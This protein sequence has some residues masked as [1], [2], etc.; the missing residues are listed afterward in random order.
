MGKTYAMLQEA[1]G[2]A[3]AG[4]DVVVGLVETHGRAE[5]E[6]LLTGLEILPRQHLDYRG[7][8]LDDLD[9]DAL[10]ARRPQL[11]LVDEL[12]HTNVPGARH[13][14][15]WQDVAEA[16]DAGI[17][18][19]TTLNIQ[20]IESLNDAVARITGVRVQETV[21]D[22]IVARADEIEL[23]DLPPEELIGRLRDGKVYREGTVGRALDNFFTKPNLTAL[24]EL[25]L[26][27]A[28]SRVDQQM[29]SL[30]QQGAV[31][32][33]WPTQDRILV[34]I[35]ESPLAK[36]LVR[37]GKRM[38]ER[39]DVPWIAI[40]VITPRH[41]GL[42][43]TARRMTTEALQLA[44]A[45]GAETVTLRA[46]PGTADAIIGFARARNATRSFSDP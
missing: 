4:V 3:K 26:R 7:Q 31:K 34:C 18:V 37:A 21:P 22:A 41:E 46:D 27:T 9:L 45:L 30:M 15:R 40:T 14:K 11:A 16:L 29:L 44:E 36:S 10:L 33:P 20:H 19:T 12:A 39:A 38:A 6:A 28:A 43:D 23:I 42:P 13:L 24:R 17:D 2:R 35:N 32:G 5:T 1:S 8:S 25:A